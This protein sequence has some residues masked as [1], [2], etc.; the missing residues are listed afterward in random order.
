[1]ICE[2]LTVRRTKAGQAAAA[3]VGISYWPERRELAI[4]SDW[5]GQT[6]K[7]R[8]CY[9][10]A[11]IPTDWQGQGFRIAREGAEEPYDVFVSA[12]SPHADTCDCRGFQRF[13]YC[14][15]VETLRY[16]TTHGHA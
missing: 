7:A 11:P 8:R 16:L 5:N 4:D 1:M 14:V 10:V 9:T 6:W 2:I 3:D 15:H 12:E 13:G